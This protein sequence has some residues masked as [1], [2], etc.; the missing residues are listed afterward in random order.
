MNMRLL[1]LLVIFTYSLTAQAQGWKDKLNQVKQHTQEKFNQK[2]NE[3]TD[4]AIDKSADKLE[5]VITGKKKDK[6]STTSSTDKSNSSN[7]DSPNSNN[8]EVEN[9]ESETANNSNEEATA[10]SIVEWSIQTDIKCTKGKDL[11]QKKL[12]DL[13]IFSS[14]VIDESSGK[15]YITPSGNQSDSKKIAID[16]INGLG[17]TAEGKKSSKKNPCL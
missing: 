5:D 15:I 12:D 16:T 7:N 13:D 17:F 4:K 9:S 8:T 6:N 14:I 11:V 10:T 1:I 3:K 2:I